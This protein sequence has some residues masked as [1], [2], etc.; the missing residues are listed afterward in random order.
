MP[1]TDALESPRASASDHEI[2]DLLARPAAAVPRPPDRRPR[3][4]PVLPMRPP[5]LSAVLIAHE[6]RSNGRLPPVLFAALGALAV[7]VLFGYFRWRGTRASADET[8]VFRDAPAA[9]S[10]SSSQDRR[11]DRAPSPWTPV[12]PSAPPALPVATPATTAPPVATPPKPSEAPPGRRVAPKPP[13][14]PSTP[15]PVAKTGLLTV[16]CTPACDDV[17]DGARSLGPSPVFK[18]SVAAGNHKLTLR[19]ND[20]PATKI[21]NVVVTEEEPLVVRETMGDDLGPRN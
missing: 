6:R 8:T 3:P 11:A 17:R 4:P 1:E 12:P 5:S 9:S 15:A 19:V 13:P 10:A 21:V 2:S 7:F 18:V 16:L 14:P 20:P